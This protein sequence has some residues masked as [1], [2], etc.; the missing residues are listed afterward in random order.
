LEAAQVAAQKQQEAELERLRTQLLFKQHEIEASRRAAPRAPVPT[1]PTGSP[2]TQRSDVPR[3]PRSHNVAAPQSLS[4][5]RPVALPP[6]VSKARPPPPG[7]VNAFV[8]PPPKNSEGKAPASVFE[9]DLDPPPLWPHSGPVTVPSHAHADEA[10]E[11]DRDEVDGQV[12][13]SE[14]DFHVD[15]AGE[16]KTMEPNTSFSKGVQPFDWVG[17]VC[18]HLPY[19]TCSGLM[20]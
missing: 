2:P 5:Q 6:R 16:V 15:L 11:I 19:L 4:P 17:W 3:T 20:F 10:M 18:L 14:V 7:F 13:Y 1:Q 9:Q 12:A 8:I